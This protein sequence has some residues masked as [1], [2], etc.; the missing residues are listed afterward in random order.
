[1]FCNMSGKKFAVESGFKAADKTAAVTCFGRIT[2]QCYD[3]NRYKTD[4]TLQQLVRTENAPR[5]HSCFVDFPQ[6]DDEQ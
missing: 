4:E 1:M 6:L 5:G 2:V 3:S